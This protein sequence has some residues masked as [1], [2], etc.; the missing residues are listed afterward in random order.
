MELQIGDII[1]NRHYDYRIAEFGNGEIVQY[2]TP[3]GQEFESTKEEPYVLWG[4]EQ[5]PGNK[6]TVWTER[7]LLLLIRAGMIATCDTGHG[8]RRLKLNER[9]RWNRA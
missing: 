4:V 9:G 6:F 8:E 7:T 2:L 1:K 3:V 5:P